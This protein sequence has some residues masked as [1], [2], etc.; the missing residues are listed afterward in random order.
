MNIELYLIK[1]KRNLN[2]KCNGDKNTFIDGKGREILLEFTKI[3]VED[4]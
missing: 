4:F 1:G 3:Q 2:E